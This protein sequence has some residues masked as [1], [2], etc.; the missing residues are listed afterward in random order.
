[1]VGPV[2]LMGGTPVRGVPGEVASSLPAAWAGQEV[3]SRQANGVAFH[4]CCGLCHQQ[5]KRPKPAAFHLQPSRQP[6][7]LASI[8]API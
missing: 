4:D 1:M 5:G 2:G 6:A 7:I 3:G 8:T